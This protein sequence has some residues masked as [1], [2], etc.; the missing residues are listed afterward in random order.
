[1]PPAN[2]PADAANSN[3][4]MT[5]PTALS[6]L[7]FNH[8]NSNAVVTEQGAFVRHDEDVLAEN[9]ADVLAWLETLGLSRLPEPSALVADFLA[10][11]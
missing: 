11:C 7:F 4:M 2:C 9:A 1:M 5:V 6:D 3:R 10:R 8:D